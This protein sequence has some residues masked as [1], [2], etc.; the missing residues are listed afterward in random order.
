MTHQIFVPARVDEVVRGCGN[1]IFVDIGFAQRGI[2]SCG[3]AFN[4]GDPSKVQFGDLASEI[5]GWIS[6]RSG[7]FHFLIEAPLSVAFDS[8]G[9]PTG[10]AIEKRPSENPRYWY[11]GAAPSML[12]ATMYLLYE[13]QCRLKTR[14]FG[15]QIRLVEGFCSFKKK[16]S[17]ERSDHAKDVSELRDVAW[18]Q[19]RTR[20]RIVAP[21]KLKTQDCDVLISAFAVSGMNSDVPPVVEV[22]DL[23]NE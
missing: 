8:E 18:G 6:R 13:V 7:P 15:E 2:K 19:G 11:M 10:R 20:G 21:H 4:D 16:N 3:V 23:P 14:G 17:G 5:V 1:W 22:G 12:V 9:N